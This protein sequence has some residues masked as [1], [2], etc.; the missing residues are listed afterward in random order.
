MLTKLHA[1]KVDHGP[2][3]SEDL[4][5]LLFEIGRDLNHKSLWIDAS[6]WLEAAHDALAAQSPESLSKDAQQLRMSIM[7]ALVKCQIHQGSEQSLEKAWNII[8]DM[9]FESGD[10][11]VV[12][13]LRLDL[14]AASP[15][16]SA[17]D[18]RDTLHR[19]A[20]TVHLTDASFSTVIHHVHKLKAWDANMAHELLSNFL[21]DRLLGLGGEHQIWLEKAVITIIWNLTTSA[22]V[23]DEISM[24][25]E[26]F[27]Q[28]GSSLGKPL[29]PSATHAAQILLW[30]RIDVAYCQAKYDD[31]E[32]WC[33]ISLHAVFGSSGSINVGKLQRK[34]ILCALGMDNA[35]KAWS[36][37]ALMSEDTKRDRSTQYL[38]Y[39]LATKC[40]DSEMAAQ[41]FDAICTSLNK[42][43]N[44]DASF[45]YACVFDAQRSG[46]QA[47]IIY[48]LQQVLERFDYSAPSG[49]HLPAL[50]RCTAR[51]LMRSSEQV[52]S[53][54]VDSLCKVFE[55]ATVQAKRSRQ[56]D[57]D[58]VFTV[59]ELD[60]FSRN[61]YNLSLRVCHIWPP[62]QT[63]RMLKAALNFIDTYPTNIDPAVSADL[64]LRRLFCNFVSC[65]LCI[66][67][68]RNEDCIESQSQYYLS[69]RHH[70]ADWRSHLPTQKSRL[71]GDARTDLTTKHATLLG[72]DFEAAARLKSW[73]DFGSIINECVSNLDCQNVK[74]YAVIADIVLASEAP[75][76]T[77]IM[78]LQQIVNATWQTEG[79]DIEKL[80]RWIRCLV[81]KALVSDNKTVERLIDQVI[82]IVE[83][84]VKTHTSEKSYPLEELEWL[85]TTTFNRAIDFYC[86]SQDTECR[87]WAEK[88]LTL[89]SLCKDGGI[90]H[91]LLQEKFQSLVWQGQ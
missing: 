37:V 90:L 73:H 76:E 11:L 51:L 21:T 38:L 74:V 59:N 26:V 57:K 71:A 83:T 86:S 45:M 1:Q 62:H 12:L 66:H 52:D 88:A 27:D 3:L 65:S 34:L 70:I 44:K 48:A 56:Q 78:S 5:D 79:R 47:Q 25:T 31:A 18:Y 54:A 87:S 23:S 17:E 53:D 16:P 80:S 32:K 9:S 61:S 58:I 30:K 40:N 46:N 85:A 68:A 19:I 2:S 89:G 81:F 39:K 77:M 29:G 15:V 72:Y 42:D 10:K 84:S 28:I 43:V 49:I 36:I 64:S 6:F 67:L 35:T 7:C 91:G 69:A 50:L 33:S 13:L 22:P 4:S 63:L 60:W 75:S 8:Q 82:T 41:C 55:G 14:L 20:R 24:L